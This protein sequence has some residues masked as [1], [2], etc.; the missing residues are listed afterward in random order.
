MTEARTKAMIR[1]AYS[2]GLNLLPRHMHE[3]IRSHVEHGREVGGFLTAMLEGDEDR[4]W[5]SAD[6]MNKASRDEWAT[7]LANHLPAECHGS[8][9]K[10]AAWRKMGGLDG[11]PGGGA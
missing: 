1:A 4:A 3:G 11:L 6:N 8:R 2:Q 7:F 5:K 10:V 9:L